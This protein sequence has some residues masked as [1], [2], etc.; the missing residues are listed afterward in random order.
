MSKLRAVVYARGTPDEIGR[1][2]EQCRL[3]AEREGTDV[4]ALATDAPDGFAGW[5]AANIMI[6][7]ERADHILIAS[8]SCIPKI[9]E[10]VTQQVPARRARR[11]NPPN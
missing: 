8:R 11:L 2:Q 1:Q 10:S 9:V 6:A 5:T 7:D 4:V 3:M